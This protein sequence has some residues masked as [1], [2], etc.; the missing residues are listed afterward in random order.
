MPKT[1]Y[2]IKYQEKINFI[3]KIAKP[4]FKISYVFCFLEQQIRSLFFFMSEKF[5]KITIIS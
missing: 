4:L 1:A 5:D 3:I 2:I